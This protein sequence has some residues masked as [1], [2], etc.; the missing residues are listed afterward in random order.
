MGGFS[1]ELDERDAKIEKLEA[2]V[3]RLKA[4][5]ERTCLWKFDE[6]HCKYDTGCGKAWSFI[7]DGIAENGLVYCPFCG[8]KVSEAVGKDPVRVSGTETLTITV[9]C[10][11]SFFESLCQEASLHGA[12]GGL[13]V[14]SP[15]DVLLLAAV[16]AGNAERG[17]VIQ[18][19]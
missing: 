9:Q 3:E 7:D 4:A 15:R 6:D 19:D 1:R 14:E 8:G 16:K 10:R 12:C 13:S 18:Q 5:D 2:A 11:H 17:V